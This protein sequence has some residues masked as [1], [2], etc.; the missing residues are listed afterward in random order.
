M[1][2]PINTD[3][4]GH[5]LR[6]AERLVEVAVNTLRLAETI[7]NIRYLVEYKDTFRVSTGIPSETTASPVS[8]PTWRD[9]PRCE[10]YHRVYDPPSESHCYVGSAPPA[11]MMNWLP[12]NCHAGDVS[13]GISRSMNAIGADF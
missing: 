7:L 12:L 9:S 3:S 10:A 1:M 11:L 4:W 5:T 13:G 8:L 6:Q 2:P